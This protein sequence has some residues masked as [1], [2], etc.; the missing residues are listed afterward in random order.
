MWSFANADWWI[1]VMSD[2]S[3]GPTGW[4]VNAIMGRCQ[5]HVIQILWLEVG[6]VRWGIGAGSYFCKMQ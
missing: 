5:E 2:T 6:F 3:S 1:R 4:R